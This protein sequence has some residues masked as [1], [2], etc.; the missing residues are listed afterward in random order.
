[1]VVRA[2]VLWLLGMR[3]RLPFSNDIPAATGNVPH[4]AD[5]DNAALAHSPHIPSYLPCLH[6]PYSLLEHT[7]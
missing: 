1:M 4:I 2:R 7:L 3:T 5:I 6:P